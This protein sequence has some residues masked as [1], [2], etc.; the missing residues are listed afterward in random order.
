MSEADHLVRRRRPLHF[1]RR[2][3]ADVDVDVDVG[4]GSRRSIRNSVRHV[5]NLERAPRGIGS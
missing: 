4:G 3:R 1:G 2:R 5:A